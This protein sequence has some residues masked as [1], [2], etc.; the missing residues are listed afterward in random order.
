MESVMAAKKRVSPAFQN[1]A[2]I[3][4]IL[5]VLVGLGLTWLT[6]W[7]PY[8]IWLFTSSL[9]LLLLY[10]FDKAQA[11][12][13]GGRVP[14]SLLHVLALLGGF[15]GGWL[16]RVVFRHKTRKPVFTLVLLASTA[17]HILLIFWI[18]SR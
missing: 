12:S 8:F 2:L 1:F 7:Q 17:L 10:G 4:T 16:G 15:T 3:A 6:S 18:L 13:Q 5:I 9:V 14:E 11:R